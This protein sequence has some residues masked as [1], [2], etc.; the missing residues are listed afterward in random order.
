[1]ESS[2]ASFCGSFWDLGVYGVYPHARVSFWHF[3]YLTIIYE[4]IQRD[5]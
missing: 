1:M 3:K 4:I 5:S 2:I